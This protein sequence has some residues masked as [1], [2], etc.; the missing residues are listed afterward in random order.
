MNYFYSFALCL[1]VAFGAQ[2]PCPSLQFLLEQHPEYS[3]STDEVQ[4]LIN[5]G[6]AACLKVVLE[7]RS[8]KR[9]IY[10][11]NVHSPFTKGQHDV[12]KLL[13]D[14]GLILA[15]SHSYFQEKHGSK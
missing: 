1:A 6:D 2:G 14:H 10:W 3:P 13:A 15:E 7:R 12:M 5:N 11:P 9:D 4:N 8:Y